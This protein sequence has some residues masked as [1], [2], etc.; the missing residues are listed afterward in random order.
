[1]SYQPVKQGIYYDRKQGR[2]M[3]HNG[4]SVRIHWSPAMLD[5][6]RRSYAR[7]KNQDLADYLGV[8]MRTMIRK[9]R[10]LGLEKD[11]RW[12]GAVWNEHRGIAH[13]AARAKGYPGGFRKGEHA[14]PEHEYKKG[15]QATEEERRKRAEA[16]RRHNRLNPHKLRERALKAWET[17]RKNQNIKDYDRT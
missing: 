4:Y 8:S 3:H 12:L 9:A 1:M 14:C 6:L 5:Y 7:T 16:V 17:R 11:P 15:H 10:E 2:I 13:M